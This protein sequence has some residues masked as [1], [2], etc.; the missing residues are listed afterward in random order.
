MFPFQ[1]TSGIFP[2]RLQG[3]RWVPLTLSRIRSNTAC[4]R[5]KAKRKLQGRKKAKQKKFIKWFA[6]FINLHK[7]FRSF[8]SHKELW[9][10]W[11]ILASS[12]K[13][14]GF[15]F[16]PIFSRILVNLLP[17]RFKKQRGLSVVLRPFPLLC[18]K[19]NQEYQYFSSFSQRFPC[20]D[21]DNR[22][23]SQVNFILTHSLG[24][25]KTEDNKKKKNSTL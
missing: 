15:N 5:K 7:S 22:L 21:R 18:L 3:K 23:A 16:A 12:L 25:L 13:F 9:C 11:S 14:M 2:L 19:E 10:I 17:Y 20:L 6:Y 1:K 4:L 24:T 8:Y